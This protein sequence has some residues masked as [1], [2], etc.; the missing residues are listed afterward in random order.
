MTGLFIE[1]NLQLI[2]TL[3]QMN[4]VTNISYKMLFNYI[5]LYSEGE[6]YYDD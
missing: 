6:C 1:L 2:D 4:D 3:F 5:D